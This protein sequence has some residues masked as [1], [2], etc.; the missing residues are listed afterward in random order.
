MDGLQ[1]KV[2]S[3]LCFVQQTST[4]QRMT[5]FDTNRASEQCGEI[6]AAEEVTTPAPTPPTQFLP[7]R[8][9]LS[10]MLRF[11]SMPKKLRL[12][13]HTTS[14]QSVIYN[15]CKKVQCPNHSSETKYTVSLIVHLAIRKHER[16]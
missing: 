13:V 5:S 11:S 15:M 9:R 8:W 4:Q 7:I 6:S 3:R 16:C 12:P 10:K 14:N 2:S 1:V